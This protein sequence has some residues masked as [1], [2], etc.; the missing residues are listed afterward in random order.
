MESPALGSSPVLLQGLRLCPAAPCLAE[1]RGLTAELLWLLL[2][3]SVQHQVSFG[4][5]I[6]PKLVSCIALKHVAAC[7]GYVRGGEICSWSPD[8]A[9]EDF[10]PALKVEASF[11]ESCLPCCC[12]VLSPGSGYVLCS[13]LGCG[14]WYL[15]LMS[16]SVLLCLV[17]GTAMGYSKMQLIVLSSLQNQK[18]V[19]SCILP[20]Y[21]TDTV[22]HLVAGKR[23]HLSGA[24]SVQLRGLLARAA[25]R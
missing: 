12:Y 8:V 24:V 1:E 22:L 23:S 11:S 10:A 17:G 13:W 19:M 14:S 2:S 9:L 7:W 3:S 20:K 25:R 21:P 6:F 18:L 15:I 4:R 16:C 5:Q